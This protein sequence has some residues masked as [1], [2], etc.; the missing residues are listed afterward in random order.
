[1]SVARLEVTSRRSAGN[2]KVFGAVGPYEQLEGTASFAVDP[3]HPLNSCI[4]D[5]GLAPRGA[6]G[7]VHF[8]ALFSILRPVDQ[9]RGSRRLLIG[10]PNRGRKV[11]GMFNL[12]AQPPGKPEPDGGPDLGDGLL[13]GNGY[14]VAECG[15]E[16]GLPPGRG[17]L[18]A[19]L[20]E[21]GEPHGPVV[22]NVMLDWQPSQDCFS[23]PFAHGLRYAQRLYPTMDVNDPEA[24]LTV[25][26]KPSASRHTVERRLWAFARSENGKAVPDA[27]SIY[28]SAGFQRGKIYELVYRAC[29]A[30]VLGL[31]LL[32]IRDIASF[33]RFG[34]PEAGN[35]CADSLDYAY[36]YGV[37]QTGSLLRH[38]LYLG[39]NEDESE[40]MVFDGILTLIGAAGRSESN[41]RF[42]VGSGGGSTGMSNA[43]PHA[44]GE[45]KDP[46][47]GKTD[48]LLKRLTQR[49]KAPRVFQVN[50][51]N[52]YWRRGASLTH[53][54]AR[55]GHDLKMPQSV[56]VY[57]IAGAQHAPGAPV[58]STTPAPGERLRYPANTLAYT[59]L[60]RAMLH[61][62]DRWVSEGVEPPS[63]NYPRVSDGTAV[64]PMS[65]QSDFT[66]IPGSDLPKYLPRMQHLDFGPGSTEGIPASLP[67]RNDGEDYPILVSAL[68][69]DR[70]EVAGLRLPDLSV[71]LP[72][73]WAGTCGTR[74][75]VPET[76]SPAFGELLSHS[77]K[78]PTS[79]KLRETPAYP[80]LRGTR[81]KK[82]IY[83]ASVRLP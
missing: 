20:P 56:R 47:S 28:L 78:M 34:S 48:G 60:V 21:A 24:S 8:T 67:G 16:W 68:D 30:P 27:A 43:F 63:S 72:P 35:P 51:A 44:F 19:D 71:P 13:M 36:A 39:L 14:T 6:D 5:I 73:T 37:S 11:T 80:S 59:P 66:A 45:E 62:L 53:A 55:E 70:N 83:C 49:N 32:G 17:V 33:L 57:S 65:L 26:D 10:V 54:D 18:T 76:R 52:E 81:Q 61:N 29:G 50:S 74:R 64:P 58:I 69:T 22:G 9:R 15:W 25:R 79:A 3:D 1:M 31:G 42:G 38:F 82:N 77:L 23:L 12:A 75:Q 46:V 40:R 4:T 7:L 41:V 2:G